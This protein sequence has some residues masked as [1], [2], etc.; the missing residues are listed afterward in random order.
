MTKDREPEKRVAMHAIR[1]PFQRTLPW[2]TQ[3]AY[4]LF[5]HGKADIDTP[6]PSTAKFIEIEDTSMEDDIYGEPAT[7]GIHHNVPI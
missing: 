2:A 4:I 3:K 1:K 5:N 6:G 7:E